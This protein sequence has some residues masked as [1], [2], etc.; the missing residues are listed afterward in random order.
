MIVFTRMVRMN[1]IVIKCT[2]CKR[3]ILKYRKI[4]KGRVLRCYKDRIA[5]CYSNQDEK[6]L[7]C[8]CGQIIG[9]DQVKFYKMKQNAFDYAGSISKK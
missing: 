2:K 4:G 8:P 5:K 6:D 7:Y 3:K 9:I 1:M